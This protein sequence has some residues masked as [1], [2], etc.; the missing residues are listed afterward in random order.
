MEMTRR[1]ARLPYEGITRSPPVAPDETRRDRRAEGHRVSPRRLRALNFP[2]PTY[3]LARL[4]EVVELFA[5][6]TR[7]LLQALRSESGT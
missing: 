5:V 2:I 7:T 4:D 6:C 3:V 1:W